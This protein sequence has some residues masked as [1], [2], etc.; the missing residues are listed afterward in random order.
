MIEL[1][2]H[3]D[4]SIRVSTLH[5]LAQKFD[6]IPN[7]TSLEAFN[8]RFILHSPL[9]DLSDV[10]TK[11]TVFQKILKTEEILERIAFEV[12]EDCFNEGIRQV[13]L[14]FS[15]SFV[16]EFNH[17]SW[18]KA[19][20]HFETGIKKAKK[21]FPAMQIGLI[22]IATRDFGID[23][24]AETVEFFLKNK[25]RL[26]G[27]DLAGNEENFPCRIFENAFKP[28]KTQ[29]M[30]ITIHA[31]EADGPEN[32]WEAIELLGAKRIGH[33][34]RCMEDPSLVTYLVKN[35]ICLEICPT[36]NWITRVVPSLEQHPLPKII[37][38]GIP[39]CINTDDPGIFSNNLPD[40]ISLCR[41]KLGLSE[42]EISLCEQN[43]I[44]HS[45]LRA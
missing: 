25:N 23:S 16:C 35:K 30:N 37:H 10:L 15:P 5:E 18:D 14:R 34:I 40:E 28:A 21:Q 31:G 13:E 11:F 19:L 17:L 8:S 4:V 2:R 24:V 7:S 3:L 33:G 45:F 38:A 22:C 1:H 29:N 9:K 36:S 42:T 27:L 43:A 32:I 39:A 6:L 20:D 41:E 44:Q 26:I 12:A